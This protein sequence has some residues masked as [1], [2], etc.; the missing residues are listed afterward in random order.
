MGGLHYE[1][2]QHL[3]ARGRLLLGWFP[4][5]LVFSYGYGFF[6]R[7]VHHGHVGPVKLAGFNAAVSLLQAGHQLGV[8]SIAQDYAAGE[9]KGGGY[10]P[11][12]N[13]VYGGCC[14]IHLFCFSSF[15]FVAMPPSSARTDVR[16]M[17]CAY[18]VEMSHVL[19][20]SLTFTD[21]CYVSFA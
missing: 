19:V 11:R 8:D 1:Q 6:S 15:W 16:D 5:S 12:P 7:Q 13:G 2:R 17:G 10:L 14:S 18:A 3:P 4:L 9:A 21:S 20:G